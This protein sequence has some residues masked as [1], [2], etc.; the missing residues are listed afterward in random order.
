MRGKELLTPDQRKDLLRLSFE[1]EKELAFYYTF[2]DFDL[3]IINR[4]RRDYNRL[5]FAIQLCLLRHPGC[6]LANI[7]MPDI[8]ENL[9]KYVADQLKVRPSIFELY[10]RRDTTR[11]EH[12]EEIR[13][14]YGYRTFTIRDYRK[15]SKA[16]QSHAAKNGSTIYLVQTALQE[17]RREKII[18][19]AIPTVE[20]AVWETRRR[21]EERI[22]N[23]LTSSLTPSQQEKLDKLLIPMEG[24]SK[25]YL[26]MVK[27]STR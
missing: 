23:V 12:L 5:G 20:R 14:E 4:H 19:P 16:L 1:T 24:T 25:T 15:L 13:Q 10:A 8:P 27:R 21:V 3:E 26:A 22:F 2:S 9:L 6:S 17:L 11:R 7:N 18:L